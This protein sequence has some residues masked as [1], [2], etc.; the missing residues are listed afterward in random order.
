MLDERIEKII[1]LAKSNSENK[2]VKMETPDIAYTTQEIVEKL[3]LLFPDEKDRPSL[4]L[5]RPD[6]ITEFSWSTS[7]W[8]I[9]QEMPLEKSLK[10]VEESKN[11]FAIF[12]FWDL[13]QRLDDR[14]GQT[15]ARCFIPQLILSPKAFKKVLICVEPLG[16]QYP[17]L[18]TPYMTNITEMYPSKKDLEPMVKR[19]LMRLPPSA[20]VSEK[21]Y[22]EVELSLLG[23]TFSQSQEMLEM[24]IFKHTGS[25]ESVAKIVDEL[26]RNKEKILADN[27]GMTILKPTSDDIPY[28]LDNLMEDLKIHKN[29]ICIPGQDREKGWLLVGTPGSGKSLLAKYLGLK[30]GFP[31]ISFNISSIMNSYVGQT[32]KNMHNLCKVLETFAPCILYI[33]EF[34]KTISTG[35]E[36]DGGT[37]TRAMGILFTFL[38]DTNAPIFVL[39]SANN[40]NPENGFAMTRKGRFSQIYWVGEPCSKARFQIL[41]ANFSK[42]NIKLDADTIN[43]LASKTMYFTGADLAWMVNEVV[44]RLNYAGGISDKAQIVSEFMVLV[45]ENE[46]RV[47]TMKAQYDPLRMWAKAYCRPAGRGP[48]E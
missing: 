3:F 19:F 39:A 30:L 26:N 9:S 4:Y 21:N 28:G 32:E 5:V 42:K 44:V 8:L 27:L 12:I 41:Q 38:N 2:V 33:D 46:G 14:E 34:E 31:A 10:I 23:L 48:E 43:D 1:L 40:L 20:V 29:Q 7:N 22:D 24:A 37:M 36:R 18:I 45:E 15:T 13:V 25:N 35:Q 11:S 47:K 6:R 17:N 16:T